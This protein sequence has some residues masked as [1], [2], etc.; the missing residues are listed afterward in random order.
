MVALYAELGIM[1]LGGRHPLA[2]G[3]RFVQVFWRLNNVLSD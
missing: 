1:V 2:A 3:V